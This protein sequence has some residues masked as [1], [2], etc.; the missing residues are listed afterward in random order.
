MPGAQTVANPIKGG[1]AFPPYLKQI[2]YQNEPQPDFTD[3]MSVRL[4]TEAEVRV[5][6][7]RVQHSASNTK[8]KDIQKAVLIRKLREFTGQSGSR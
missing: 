7:D 6:L 5:A 1:L 3:Y 8:T 4:A 2:C